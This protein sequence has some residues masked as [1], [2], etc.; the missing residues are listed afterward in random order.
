[1]LN[2]VV[3]SFSAKAQMVNSLPGCWDRNLDTLKRPLTSIQPS[4][5]C[6]AWRSSP[7]VPTTASGVFALRE[8]HTS[9]PRPPQKQSALS[10]SKK[11]KKMRQAVAASARAAPSTVC[12]A[13]PH[14]EGLHFSTTSGGCI[15]S[16]SAVDFSTT[17]GWW[18]MSN[19]AVAS[20]PAKVNMANSPPKCRDKKFETL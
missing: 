10:C 16:N 11:T 17:S 14:I 5:F 6:C 19:S 9:G 13:L 12:V 15:V 2:S 7:S 4:P 8:A 3:E 1:M 18:I 20:F